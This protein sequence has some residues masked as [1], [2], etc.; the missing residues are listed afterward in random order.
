MA[1]G[2]FINVLQKNDVEKRLSINRTL[3]KPLSGKRV[4]GLK[5]KNPN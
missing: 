4:R 3:L 1:R 2:C 5:A